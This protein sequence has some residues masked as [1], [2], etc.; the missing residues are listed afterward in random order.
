MPDKLYTQLKK[1]KQITYMKMPN[2][3]DG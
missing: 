1:I 3:S 2:A